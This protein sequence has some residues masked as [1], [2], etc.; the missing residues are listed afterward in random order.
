M[1]KCLE[2]CMN[3]T[4][5]PSTYAKRARAF[6]EEKEDDEKDDSKMMEADGGVCVCLYIY[7]F[8]WILSDEAHFSSCVMNVKTSIHMTK[9]IYVIKGCIN[10]IT[11]LQ[12]AAVLMNNSKMIL[13]K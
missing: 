10:L 8:T 7:D 1:M 9:A 4:T 6:G 11:K 12:L 13:P 5:P 3:K 2:L